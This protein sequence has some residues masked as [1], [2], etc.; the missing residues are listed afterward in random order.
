MAITA[1]FSAGQL[2]IIGDGA[3]DVV[4]VSTVNVGGVQQ[5]TVNGQSIGDGVNAAD[6]TSISADLG[7]GADRM[8][9]SSLNL[10]IFSGLTDGSVTINGGLGNDRIEGTPLGDI[11]TGGGGDD[12]IR[13][14]G[15]DDQVNGGSGADFLF[16]GD[17][18]DLIIGGAGDDLIFGG[19]GSDDLRGAG[20]AD[21]LYGEAGDD[22]LRG[23]TG[24]DFLYGGT[25]NDRLIGGDGSDYQAG[26]SGD[27][28]YLYP[29]DTH[30]GTDRIDEHPDD[31]YDS[32]DARS[33]TVTS[34]PSLDSTEVQPLGSSQSIQFV[35][36]GTVEEVLRRNT[37]GTGGG[38]VYTV[39][40]QP[41]E[42]TYVTFRY[43]GGSAEYYS[44]SIWVY[45]ANDVD[46]EGFPIDPIDLTT[47]SF[48]EGSN[49]HYNFF[50][51]PYAAGTELAFFIESAAG[52]F[53]SVPALNDDGEHAL[54]ALTGWGETLFSWKAEPNTSGTIED[55]EF[56]D[57]ILGVG[58][59]TTYPGR[60]DEYPYYPW[61]DLVNLEIH[62]NGENGPFAVVTEGASTN[63]TFTFWNLDL[64][65]GDFSPDGQPTYRPTGWN[66]EWGTTGGLWPEPA[67][68]DLIVPYWLPFGDAVLGEDFLGLPPGGGVDVIVIP[69]G[70]S[71]AT[72]T[73]ALIDDEVSESDE[74]L[75]LSLMPVG[76]IWNTHVPADVLILDDDG[77]TVI[78]DLDVDSDNSGQIDRT[79]AEEAKEDLEGEPGKYVSVQG[80]RV[81]MTLDLSGG[82]VGTLSITSGADRVRVWTSGGDL[83]LSESQQSVPTDQLYEGT[84]WV[85]AIRPSISLGDIVF[86]LTADDAAPDVVRM[87]AIDVINVAAT[88]AYAT[89]NGPG[90]VGSQGDFGAFTFSRPE[91]NSSRE[92]TLE[93]IV[94][95]SAQYG[96]DKDY[97]FE[98][99][100]SFDS[101]TRKG[102]IH[103][104][105]GRAAATLKVILANDVASE[106]DETITVKL[107]SLDGEPIP[108]DVPNTVT[109]LDDDGLGSMLSRNVDVVSTGLVADSISNGTVS[110]GLE[111]GDA[112][113]VLPMAPAGGG[114]G[115]RSD[116]QLRPVASIEITLPEAATE[117]DATLTI[118]SGVLGGGQPM[119]FT[120]A[121][122]SVDSSNTIRFVVLGDNGVAEYL[123]TGH[124]DY[125]IEIT[126]DSGE[127]QKTRTV[128]GETEIVNLVNADFGEAYFGKRWW[129]DGLDRLIPGDGTTAR[130]VD[131]GLAARQGMALVRGD[132]TSAWY[133]VNEFPAGHTTVVT[134]GHEDYVEL[135]DWSTGTVATPENS[136]ESYRYAGSLSD[137]ALVDA[138]LRPAAAAL[139]PKAIWDL[140]DLEPGRQYQLFVTY[141]PGWDR[142]DAATYT[143]S[144]GTRVGSRVASENDNVTIVNQQY[145]PGETFAH[146]AVWRSIGYYTADAGGFLRVTLTNGSDT[147]TLVAD[148]VML[149]DDWNFEVPDGSFDTLNVGEYDPSSGLYSG[150]LEPVTEAFTLRDKTGTTHV[151]DGLGR[152]MKSVDRNENQTQLAYLTDSK[153]S[154]ITVQGG[155]TWTYRYVDGVLDRI[156]DF[157]GRVFDYT[158]TSGLLT[159]IKLPGP[160]FGQGVV[161]T[162]FTYGGPREQLDTVTDGEEHVTR[163]DYDQMSQAVKKVTNADG[164]DWELKPY[165]F[166]GLGSGTGTFFAKSSGKIGA[167]FDESEARATYTD[168][169]DHVWTYQ[170][171]RF[172]LMT[173]KSAPGTASSGHTQN[174]WKRERNAHGLVT[175]FTEPAGAGGFGGT[176]GELVTEYFYDN[177][178]SHTQ[179]VSRGNLTKVI[180]PQA[181][182]GGSINIQESWTYSSTFSV[183]TSFTDGRGFTTTYVLDGR[184]N[185]TGILEPL[186]ITTNLEYTEAPT[187]IYGLAGGLVK[188]VRDPRGYL[189]TTE[190]FTRDDGP[191]LS[192]LVKRVTRGTPDLDAPPEGPINWDDETSQRF[193]YDERRN[194]TAAIQEM[195]DGPERVT[196][197]VFDTLDRLVTLKEPEVDYVTAGGAPARGTPTTQYRYDRMGR[198]AR[199]TNPLGRAT[200]YGYDP[201]GRPETTTLPPAQHY[202]NGTLLQSQAVLINRYDENGNL[203]ESEDALGK[204]TVF[205][206]DARNLVETKTLPEISVQAASVYGFTYDTAG[207]LATLTSPGA[208]NRVTTYAYDSLHRRL[209][210]TRPAPDAA[211]GSTHTAPRTEY[212]YDD[213][214]NRASMT[215]PVGRLT[216]YVYDAVNRLVLVT[217]PGVNANDPRTETRYE[218]DDN[219]NLVKVKDAVG[220]DFD[221]VSE[222]DGLNRKVRDTFP[223]V[224]QFDED[225]PDTP[226]VFETFVTYGYNDASER[227]AQTD[228]LGR[229]TTREYD[230]AGRLVKVIQ[231]PAHVGVSLAPTTLMEYD[232]AGNLRFVYDPEQSAAK[233]PTNRTEYQYD[234]LNRQILKRDSDPDTTTGSGR[235]VTRTAY[236]KNGNVRRV[237]DPRGNATVYAYNAQNLVTEVT[238]PDP[239]VVAPDSAEDHPSVVTTSFYDPAGNRIRETTTVP[240]TTPSIMAYTTEFAFD[241]LNRIYQVTDRTGT[242]TRSTYYADSRLKRETQ[243]PETDHDR[244]TDYFYDGLGRVN[245]VRRER[246]ASEFDVTNTTYDAVGNLVEIEDPVFN[247]TTYEYD[248]L[249]RKT[250][251][252]AVTD[253][254]AVTRAYVYDE[255]GN[256]RLVTDR[257][258]RKTRYDY[259]DLNRRV[260]ESWLGATGQAYVASFGYDLAG[261]LI[262]ATDTYGAATHSEVSLDLDQSYR[263]SQIATKLPGIAPAAEPT[264]FDSMVDYQYDLA[265]NRTRSIVS[266]NGVQELRTTY[267]FDELNRAKV[268]HQTGR[269]VTPKFV[270]YEYHPDGRPTEIKRE[271][272][273]V[274]GATSAPKLVGTSVWDYHA[275]T[276]LLTSLTHKDAAGGVEVAYGLDYDGLNRLE[277]YTESRPQA[278]GTGNT[279]APAI[280]QYYTYDLSDQVKTAGDESF[281]P[282]ANGNRNGNGYETAKDNRLSEDPNYK[283]TYDAEGNR[284]KR[285]LHSGPD[286]K[287]VQAVLRTPVTGD[288]GWSTG[289][290]GYGGSQQIGQPYLVTNPDGP[291]TFQF[292]WASWTASSLP[293]GSY[294][295]Y[296]TWAPVSGGL[297]GVPF[298][299][300]Y[301]VVGGTGTANSNGMDFSA[302]P[303]NDLTYDGAVW[304][305]IGSVESSG[306]DIFTVTLTTGW[307]DAGFIAADAI[308]FK[309]TSAQAAKT[310]YEW[311]HQNRLTKVISESATFAADGTPT[312]APFD[313][314]TYSYDV[315]GRRAAVSNEVVAGDPMLVEGFHRVSF[316]DSSHV[317]WTE[318]RDTLSGDVKRTQALLWGA[319]PDSLLAIQDR[320]SSGSR[321]A[322][323]TLPDQTGSIKD[324]LGLAGSGDTSGLLLT[325]RFSAFGTP[326]PVQHW[327]GADAPT[328][329]YSD[330]AGTSGFFYAGQEYDAETGLSYS[331]GRYYDPRSAEFISQDAN[332]SAGA[333]T[334]PYRRDRNDP[335]NR[336]SRSRSWG[337]WWGHRSW[338]SFGYDTFFKDSFTV[339]ANTEHMSWLGQSSTVFGFFVLD[340]IGVRGLNDAFSI[341]D[342][343][344][345]HVQSAEERALDFIGGVAGIGFVG[346]GSFLAK[347]AAGA[348][349]G[350]IRGALRTA[351]AAARSTVTSVGRAVGGAL[352]GDVIDVGRG[353]GSLGRR[354]APS[355]GMKF[356]ST[357]QGGPYEAGRFG[358]GGTL[359]ENDAIYRSGQVRTERLVHEAGR[360]LGVDVG[361]LVDEIVYVP[362]SKAP[363]FVTQNGRRIVALNE[364]AVFGG[365][366]SLR[367]LKAAHELGH[368]NAFTNRSLIGR[369]SYEAEEIL[370]ESQARAALSTQL[371]PRA[372]RN[373]IQYEND[374]RAL[375]GMPLLPST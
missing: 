101:A 287:G 238:K 187:D 135:G 172:G 312:Y 159:S 54:E 244:R 4:L 66:A 181:M 78:V 319:E 15:G 90:G 328:G 296:A 168:A 191:T 65:Q 140:E 44:G 258:G 261:N 26:E 167:F 300:R 95:G 62:P 214:D 52:R 176:L 64:Y 342:A 248:A 315:L 310:T 81:P 115:Y 84:V 262:S 370:V 157:A 17:G 127:S 119:T 13:G 369:L 122:G 271:G 229:T 289:N 35:T 110:I 211:Y 206:Y 270:S 109:I 145:T 60:S 56:D 137:V 236:D 327:S 139:A 143:I 99:Q 338:L 317:V 307:V 160:G 253:Q 108:S 299:I 221:V 352:G 245:E 356:R 218:Y 165:L 318:T 345:G 374:F 82:V 92:R 278:R 136:A 257:N 358:R 349:I 332:G 51:R 59:L 25:G 72:L 331:Q 8:N 339:A 150:G 100:V 346:A 268:I 37:P 32:V 201:M 260:T 243:A 7:G 198:L 142:T 117:F 330:I 228:Q 148:A 235:P 321:P 371:S 292:A 247:K 106:W 188:E 203:R 200:E 70:E 155:L 132:N 209:S 322:V 183:P 50:E 231:P 144:G 170:L 93:F 129:V 91:N 241:N 154:T 97:T 360:Q 350:G 290:G 16:G 281:E 363:F 190:Y 362:G 365:D 3:S 28:T 12:K 121:S 306:T 368:A 355:N 41:G 267:R 63:L 104:P 341:H 225:N 163:I 151:F 348:A 224:G 29:S 276:G 353:L 264:R 375:L 252:T 340:A 275:T 125:D 88:N 113:L 250:K 367:L 34:V 357:Y 220:D 213:N 223:A 1:G 314:T 279:P 295:V 326:E 33:L 20:G 272:S 316:Y 302:S 47:L 138:A 49:G 282:G 182:L 304:V 373:S 133:A 24:N 9:L 372:L 297:Q 194:R 255:V 124:Y 86:T 118:A 333:D 120:A 18:D 284:I 227:V 308:L 31:G 141:T 58:T 192:G 96:L 208:G 27:D 259:D 337:E 156:I 75:S 291:E 204:V 246:A 366:E 354:F 256:L 19:A 38:G 273:L 103:I 277:H 263:V 179:P 266:V 149:V 237:T 116:D 79:S 233:S 219:G 158:V 2:S 186:D 309:A 23:G 76:S 195:G 230:A 274:V 30:T 111:K 6:V 216:E 265:G 298:E 324:Y 335:V 164:H 126:V 107:L 285:E 14:H 294:D 130:Y 185:T 102:T 73:L 55:G 94:S 77:G 71:S 134:R 87:T 10:T 45:D 173:A 69:A 11:L 305:K 351:A 215:D 21:L 197:F 269:Y 53:Y 251:E 162:S 36:A 61:E 196:A 152:L 320:V 234:A 5:V 80:D 114:P 286:T 226:S 98:G 166:D 334:N 329:A 169:R 212:T 323:W 39:P 193:E 131:Q 105:A 280:D 313:V 202:V 199:T 336:A 147:G 40:G 112:Q 207:N 42:T 74:W 68:F 217:A 89:E 222:Y 48:S 232:V 174:I 361:S 128:R 359:W 283:Y 43:G 180:Y 344:D 288:E 146:G 22:T 175:R 177:Q 293:A 303:P 311:D 161:T 46:S 123:R 171:D 205:A 301:P 57:I 210:E 189:T 254:G 85:E 184:G 239:G 178:T 242:V 347:P 343:A 153:L 325:R 249:Y 67:A 364:A 83:I 240:N